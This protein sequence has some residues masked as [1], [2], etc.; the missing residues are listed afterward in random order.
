M[1]A[2]KYI[3]I[4]VALLCYTA[5]MS[6]YSIYHNEGRLPKD[7]F[8]VLVIELLI[9]LALFFLLRLRERRRKSDD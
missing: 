8:L 7:F 9:T 2:K 5:A 1:K 4:P 6:C 3:V